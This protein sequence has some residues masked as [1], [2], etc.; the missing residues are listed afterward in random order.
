MRTCIPRGLSRIS[1]KCS[2]A[3]V[4]YLTEMV[5][6][7][8]FP[9]RYFFSIVLEHTQCRLDGARFITWY[10]LG[11]CRVLH[12]RVS[13]SDPT[14][15]FPP[16]P[17]GGLVQVRIRYCEPVPHVFEHLHHFPQ[18]LQPPSSWREN[19]VVWYQSVAFSY[20][21]INPNGWSEW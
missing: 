16:Y 19:I 13:L 4:T 7:I 14:Q 20:H 9:K 3:Q 1:F 6:C 8:K 15:R 12:A 11:Q 2:V 18:E 17:G 21:F 5:G 10:S